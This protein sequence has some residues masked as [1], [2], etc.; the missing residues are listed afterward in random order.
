MVYK[1]L[2]DITWW[3]MRDLVHIIQPKETKLFWSSTQM[4]V[5]AYFSTGMAPIVQSELSELTSWVRTTL[6]N[7]NQCPDLSKFRT[8]MKRPKQYVNVCCMPSSGPRGQIIWIVAM[9]HLQ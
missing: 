8:P 9:V 2:Q 3:A 6:G 1:I 5:P 7:S 4:N